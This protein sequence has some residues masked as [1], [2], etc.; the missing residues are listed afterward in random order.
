VHKSGHP[1]QQGRTVEQSEEEGYLG[2]NLVPHTSLH[3]ELMIAVLEPN[4]D[5]FGKL[6]SKGE[7]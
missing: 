6:V 1:F 5:A 4:E 7:G 3:A 2:G